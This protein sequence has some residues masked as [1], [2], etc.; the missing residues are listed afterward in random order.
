V[1]PTPTF[2][3]T[4]TPSIT[5]TPSETA[6]IIFTATPTFTATPVIESE[7]FRITKAENYPQPFFPLRNARMYIDFSVSQGCKSV[8]FS[9]Y[10]S[11]YRRILTKEI[12]QG[13]AAG[14]RRL[15]LDSGELQGLA[16][17]AYFWV[18][19]AESLDGE[20]AVSKVN[21]FLILK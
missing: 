14:S 20:R 6:Q 11:G 12:A 15:E 1:T 3:R 2:T 7:T 4:P 19:E 9:V 5:A 21:T 18:L 16:S 8:K 10:T 13:T 17:G